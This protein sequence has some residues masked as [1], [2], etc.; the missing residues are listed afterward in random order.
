M[1]S[2]L[3][4]NSYLKMQSS[5]GKVRLFCCDMEGGGKQRPKIENSGFRN[6]HNK[7]VQ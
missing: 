5:K 3:I 1:T 7:V 2:S 6:E 4:L